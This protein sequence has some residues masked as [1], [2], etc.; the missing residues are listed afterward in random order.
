[1][2]RAALDLA[3]AVSSTNP[4]VL[5][6]APTNHEIQGYMS[7]RLDFETE[8]EN[9]AEDAVKDMEFGLV[10]GYGGGDQP[11]AGPPPAPAPEPD[12]KDKDG[13]GEEEEVQMPPDPIETDES[14]ALKLTMLDIY[15]EKLDRRQEAK[16]FVFDRGMLDFKKV[17]VFFQQPPM[18]W[19]VVLTSNDRSGKHT[20]RNDRRRTVSS[21]T[22]TS[23]SQNSRPLR[24]L[25][26][27]ST[28]SCVSLPLPNS[29]C[30]QVRTHLQRAPL[31][32]TEENALRA[33]IKELQLYRENGITSLADAEKWVA[34][35]ATRVRR[36]FPFSPFRPKT[37]LILITLTIPFQFRR[38]AIS[39]TKRDVPPRRGRR[40]GDKTFLT[41]R[42]WI[43]YPICIC[44]CVRL[45][46]GF[47]EP[48]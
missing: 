33:R 47:P 45:C 20:R 8:V 9:E 5:T 31:T 15:Y 25:R 26:S 6:S 28:A 38:S 22:S 29:K 27:S 12:K 34:N 2:R 19:V 7:G 3:N 24:T 13:G 36:R 35:S 41:S 1:M 21:S 32:H 23:H 30:L 44:I 43:R 17:S 18:V 37:C 42:I 11:E 48:C 40:R 4:V 14:V 10:W 46:I 16:A 39:K